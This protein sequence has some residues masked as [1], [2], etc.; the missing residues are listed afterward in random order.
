MRQA[1]APAAVICVAV[2]RVS[3]QKKR[4]P[5]PEISMRPTPSASRQA[6]AEEAHWP[7]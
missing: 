2:Q 7:R 3:Y 6:L 5:P 4:L 1:F